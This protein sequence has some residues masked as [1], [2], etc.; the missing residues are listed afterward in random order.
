MNPL[1]Q[2]PAADLIAALRD[3][4]D[5]AREDQVAMATRVIKLA[6]SIFQIPVKTLLAKDRTPAHQPAR[7][8][9]M[10]TLNHLGL[11]QEEIALLFSGRDHGTVSHAVKRAP[12]LALRQDIAPLA[13]R[14]RTACALPPLAPGISSQTSVKTPIFSP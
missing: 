7:L 9:A 1:H 12:Q 2:Y 8:I 3:H 10:A 6:A 11:P 5:L 13:H 14:F 4:P